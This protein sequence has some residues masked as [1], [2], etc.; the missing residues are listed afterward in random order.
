MAPCG[1]LSLTNIRP[2]C[3]DDLVCRGKGLFLWLP[4][5]FTP[6][7]WNFSNT[8]SLSASRIPGSSY[9]PPKPRPGCRSVWRW[10]ERPYLLAHIWK[11]YPTGYWW[12]V[13]GAARL[14]WHTIPH[15]CRCR[16]VSTGTWIGILRYWSA[17]SPILIS[18]LWCD[19]CG[20]ELRR[21]QHILLPLAFILLASCRYWPGSLCCCCSSSFFEG[22]VLLGD[23]DRCFEFMRHCDHEMLLLLVDGELSFAE[24]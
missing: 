15:Q 20:V 23:G 13:A 5:C 22:F 4:G 7:R 21:K 24:R 14:P 11:R 19:N 10:Y 16:S 17:S 9:R 12:P 3:S 2:L 1:W 18:S 8:L 6:S